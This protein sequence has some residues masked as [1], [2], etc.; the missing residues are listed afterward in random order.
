MVSAL[1]LLWSL[2]EDD[3]SPAAAEGQLALTLASFGPV[4][5]TIFPLQLPLTVHHPDAF[6]SWFLHVSQG[7]VCAS[8]GWGFAAAP[9]RS[10]GSLVGLG[11]R[12][13]YG[14][15]LLA[16]AAVRSRDH[17]S[18]IQNSAK[19]E[20]LISFYLIQNIG[21]DTAE[22]EPNFGPKSEKHLVN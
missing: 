10:V 8:K 22:N 19:V 4:A 16:Y 6:M 12:A 5:G 13:A 9:G 21:A 17:N 1:R 2:W 18:Y 3:R 11:L 20:I 15:W 14:P 7:L